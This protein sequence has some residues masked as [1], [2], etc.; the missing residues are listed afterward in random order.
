MIGAWTPG[1]LVHI[2]RAVDLLTRDAW[3]TSDVQSLTEMLY[4]RWYAAGSGLSTESAIRPGLLTA[5]HAGADQWEDA[6]VLRIGL[7]GAIVVRTT[8]GHVRAIP[9]GDYASVFGSPRAGLLPRVGDAV[10]VRRRNGCVVADGW[11]QT[12]QGPR[13]TALDGAVSRVYLAPRPPALTTIVSRT[14]AILQSRTTTDRLAWTLKVGVHEGA[15]SRPDAMVVYVPD[16]AALPLIHDLADQLARLVRPTSP[17]FTRVVVPGIGWAEDPG[18]GHS[19]GESRCQLVARA[20]HD[21]RHSSPGPA[22]RE[23]AAGPGLTTH[24]LARRLEQLGLDPAQPHRRTRA[25]DQPAVD[26]LTVRAT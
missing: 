2:S 12:W 14:T 26:Q 5:A 19:F 9:R 8:E 20:V 23:G 1:D 18:D 25:S 17:P 10:R 15:T 11:W 22:A 13:R 6:D 16:V 3:Q 4:S 21:L 7:A 24:S